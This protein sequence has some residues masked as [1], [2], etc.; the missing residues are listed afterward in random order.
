MPIRDILGRIV[1]GGKG[2]DFSGSGYDL[3]KAAQPTR[4]YMRGKGINDFKAQMRSGFARPNLFSVDIS[5]VT[6]DKAARYRMS[7]FQA[8]IPGIS[9][10]TTDK[11]IGFRS[12]AYQ[13]LFSDFTL[14][15][16]VSSGLEELQFWQSWIDY[17]V[18][19]KTNHYRHPKQYYGTVT[20]TQISR[21]GGPSGQWIFHDAYPKQIDPIALDY[22]TNDAIIT[23]NVTMTYRNFTHNYLTE[24]TLTAIAADVTTRLESDF[25]NFSEEIMGEIGQLKNR[26][27]TFFD[28]FNKNTGGGLSNSVSQEV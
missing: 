1:S 15:F 24:Q 27:N 9:I 28:S 3:P 5:S 7:C 2:S 16:Y 26:A 11:D 17:I 18:N 23:S 19:A 4:E 12:V 6:T 10:A 14:G 13:K 20:V 22:S 21:T 25:R 8:Q